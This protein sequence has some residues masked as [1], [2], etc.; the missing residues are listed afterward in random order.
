[1]GKFRKGDAVSIEG[2]I[3]SNHV[4]DGSGGGTIKVRIAPYHDVFVSMDAITMRRATIEVGDKVMR[5]D[6]G[7][8]R[9]LAIAGEN[10]WV[11]F[12]GGLDGYDTWDALEVTRVDETEPVADL[13][14]FPPRAP[15]FV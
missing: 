5:K 12:N 8:G 1:M 10:L 14:E 11:E 15:E 9:V 4:L 6:E 13:A 3:D 7:P 2:V